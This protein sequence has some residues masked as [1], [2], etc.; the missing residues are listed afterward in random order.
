MN[1][2]LPPESQGDFARADLIDT[3]KRVFAAGEDL[4]K[5][6]GIYGLPNDFE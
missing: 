5:H 3:I 2:Y 6:P 1:S 4:I